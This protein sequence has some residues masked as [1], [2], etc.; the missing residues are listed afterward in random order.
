MLVPVEI[1]R[2]RTPYAG[3][4]RGGNQE[5]KR[6]CVRKEMSESLLQMTVIKLGSSNHA[7]TMPLLQV[8]SHSAEDKAG[9]RFPAGTQGLTLCLR[10]EQSPTSTAAQVRATA[11]RQ[12]RCQ[13][14]ASA[15]V[16][17]PAG[18]EWGL[19]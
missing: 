17:A 2:E 19:L 1:K 3:K 4:E 18:A 11:Q 6:Q 12:P 10:G 16:A 15:G 14:W 9:T 13:S 5:I 7:L 8:K